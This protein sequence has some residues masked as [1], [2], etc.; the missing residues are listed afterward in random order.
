MTM[1]ILS[2]MKRG[3]GAKKEDNTSTRLSGRFAKNKNRYVAKG[4]VIKPTQ[5]PTAGSD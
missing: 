2:R 1:N 5:P 4:R 3:E